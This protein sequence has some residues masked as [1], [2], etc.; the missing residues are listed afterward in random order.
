MYLCAMPKS[1]SWQ[2]E[3]DRPNGT[4]KTSAPR[5]TPCIRE[6][7]STLKGK[8]ENSGEREIPFAIVA[9]FGDGSVTVSMP[10][11]RANALVAIA[12]VPIW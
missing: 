3:T 6:P 2:A 5:S 7:R 1:A 10:R 4:T 8:Q 11:R 9:R 12:L